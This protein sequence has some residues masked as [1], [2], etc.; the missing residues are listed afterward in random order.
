MLNILAMGTTPADLYRIGDQLGPGLDLIRVGFDVMVRQVNGMDWVRAGTGGSSTRLMPHR[1]RNPADRWWRL[2]AG[3][4]YS[5]LLDVFQNG[6]NHVV[7]EPVRDMPLADYTQVL[8]DVNK[9][10]V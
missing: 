6:K 3:S 9:F 10:F 7:W 1:L 5:P 2:P 8:K 4:H